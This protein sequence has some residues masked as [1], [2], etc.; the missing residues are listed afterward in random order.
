M[1]QGQAMV[2][3]QDSVRVCGPGLAGTKVSTWEPKSVVMKCSLR[4][5]GPRLRSD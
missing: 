3:G 1:P 5:R 2:G 4:E